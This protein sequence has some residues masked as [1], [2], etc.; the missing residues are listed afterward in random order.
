MSIFNIQAA[1]PTA[2]DIRH[3]RLK[4][5]KYGAGALV[6]A[7]LIIGGLSLWVQSE[8]QGFVL[9]IFVALLLST[10]TA[11][12]MVV[13]DYL[14]NFKDLADNRCEDFYQ[15][16]MRTPEG[17]GYREAVLKQARKFTTAEHHAMKTWTQSRAHREACKTL[18]NIPA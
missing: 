1:P 2:A 17:E 3:A 8:R 12:A 14:S 6:V 9:P 5:L 4:V 15:L 11:T 18:Y 13:E 7:L 10:L 16:S